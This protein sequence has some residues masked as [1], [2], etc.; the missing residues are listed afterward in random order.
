[1]WFFV[2]CY[3]APAIVKTSSA[4]SWKS[5]DS[6]RMV[7]QKK[8][9]CSKAIHTP[10]RPVNF[11]CFFILFDGF[12]Q[13]FGRMF[14]CLFHTVSMLYLY[15]IHAFARLDPILRAGQQAFGI[16]HRPM[17]STYRH[18]IL[19]YI[20][21]WLYPLLLPPDI[22]FHPPPQIFFRSFAETR[23][24]TPAPRRIFET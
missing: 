8:Y 16:H 19:R 1:M 15:F 18:C 2:F 5:D 6:N 20:L 24:I 23:K 11:Y 7:L 10:H 12:C 4:F 21:P 13:L 14:P 3:S 22:T 9:S 17:Q